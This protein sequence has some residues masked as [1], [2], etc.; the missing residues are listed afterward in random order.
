MIGSTRLEKELLSDS[1]QLMSTHHRAHIGTK[2]HI[3]EIMQR[4]RTQLENGNVSAGELDECVR[5][6]R[7]EPDR[8]ECMYGGPDTIMWDRWEWH[9]DKSAPSG[10]SLWKDANNLVPH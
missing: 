6:F 5:A 7:F 2:S 8:L 10:A 3:T 4:T 9:R 1:Q